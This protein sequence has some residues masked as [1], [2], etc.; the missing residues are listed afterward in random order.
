MAFPRADR[1]YA[2]IT[3]AAAGSLRAILSQKDEFDNYN[4]I[5]NAS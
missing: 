3:A 2:L 5:S 4:A 1:Q